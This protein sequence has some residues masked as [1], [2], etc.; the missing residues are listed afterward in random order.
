MDWLSFSYKFVENIKP[1]MK[2]P[3]F[4]SHL[5]IVV[6]TKYKGEAI[7][8]KKF[9]ESI[10]ISSFLPS[11]RDVYEE[12]Q[13]VLHMAELTNNFYEIL[14]TEKGVNVIEKENLFALSY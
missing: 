9:N 7:T 5:R 11:Y 14:V 6:S 10:I 1:D 3:K 4:S 12:R 13:R 2:F 8:Q